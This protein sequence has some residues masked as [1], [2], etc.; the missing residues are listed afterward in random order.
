MSEAAGQL[1]PIAPLRVAIRS[2]DAL[3]RAALALMVSRSG[4]LVVGMDE[5]ADVVLAD[6]SGLAG[7]TRSVVRLGGTED[8]SQG[9]LPR[10]ADASQIDAAIR[11]VAAGLIVRAPGPA[12]PA[13]PASRAGRCRQRGWPARRCR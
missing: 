1:M 11:A 4:H 2:N 7:E 3:R 8:G 6:G 13:A 10:G 5:A 12:E 9:A